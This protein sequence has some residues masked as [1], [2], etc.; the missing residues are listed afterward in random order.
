LIVLIHLFTRLLL[1][2]SLLT[3]SANAQHLFGN[4]SCAD[5]HEWG[6]K[7]KLTWLNAYLVPLNLTNVARKKPSVDTFSQ[8]PS[9]DPAVSFVG[10]FCNANPDAFASVGAIRFLDDLTREPRSK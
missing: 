10:G 9:L 8:L 5:W 1:L 6:A 4:P 7:E 3:F 2:S